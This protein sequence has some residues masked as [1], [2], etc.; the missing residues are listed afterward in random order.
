M[1]RKIWLISKISYITIQ[2][3][4]TNQNADIQQRRVNGRHYRNRRI[5]VF[6]KE[7]Q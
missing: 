5:G 7:L 6:M 1:T 4:A 2:T 3:I